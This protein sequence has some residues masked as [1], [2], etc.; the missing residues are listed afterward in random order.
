MELYIFALYIYSFF[1]LV[2]DTVCLSLCIFVLLLMSKKERPS[3]RAA[4]ERAPFRVDENQT[5]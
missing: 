3:F 2:N 4:R 5:L 1:S